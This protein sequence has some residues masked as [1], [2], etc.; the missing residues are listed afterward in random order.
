MKVFEFEKNAKFLFLQCKTVL[1]LRELRD[2]G[3][4]GEF[5]K[6]LRHLRHRHSVK[7]SPEHTS[8][9]RAE[10]H[11]QIEN[12]ML[13]A[14]RYDNLINSLIWN[15]MTVELA[16]NFSIKIIEDLLA[17]NDWRKIRG[18]NCAYWSNEMPDVWLSNFLCPFWCMH[19]AE[20]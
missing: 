17:K 11:L 7:C 8:W 19:R 12:F 5:S 16:N 13:L 6:I 1:H 9:R 18:D 14:N 15:G 20:S 3:D 4:A 2:A 10:F